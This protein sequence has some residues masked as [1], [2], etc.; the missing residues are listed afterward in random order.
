MAPIWRWRENP[1][2][3]AHLIPEKAI[4]GLIKRDVVLNPGEAALLI[5]DGKVED[6]VTQTRLK[7]IGGGFGNWWTRYWG[8]ES[9][10]ELLFLNTTPIDIEIPIDDK[11]GLTTKDRQK[12]Y[13][14]TTI[15]FQFLQEDV[16]KIINLM[17][18]KPLLTKNKL[19]SRIHD[20]LISMVFSNEIAKHDAEEFHGNVAIIKDMETTASVE[21]RKT[22]GI[23]GLHLL[24]MYTVW[25]KTAYDELKEYQTELN[26]LYEK[27]KSYTDV[28]YQERLDQLDRNHTEQ[29]KAQEQKW[30]VHFA[31]LYAQEK[32]KDIHWD[33]EIDRTERKFESEL[34][35]QKKTFDEEFRED[36]AEL[37]MALAAKRRLQDIKMERQEKEADVRI[38]EKEQDLSFQ[39]DQM[40]MQTGSTE[41]IMSQALQTGAADSES[42]KEMM[43]QQSMQKALDRES[44]KVEALS[45]AEKARYELGTYKASEDRERDYEKERME[46]SAKQMEAA[47]QKLP[48]TLVHGASST[49]VMTRVDTGDDRP[50]DEKT[51]D[52]HECWNCGEAVPKGANVCPHCEETLD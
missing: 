27:R 26:T 40:A 35:I 19:T 31:E 36:Q 24:K 42:L 32:V 49:P 12:M 13:G 7:R 4:K 48:E 45:E 34:E 29:K 43:R 17:E 38:K 22:F 23:W 14:K 47:K 9:G 37:D 5:K 10:T 50:G 52:T 6:V 25:G 11:T 51:D 2:V 41:R 30:D 20:E 21:M 1:N 16:P 44:E 39:R 28:K 18:R 3:I 46:L 15:R 33:A 8:H